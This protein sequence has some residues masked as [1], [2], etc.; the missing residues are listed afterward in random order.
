MFAKYVKSIMNAKMLE[1]CSTTL[2]QSVI[3]AV[4][5]DPRYES[6]LEERRKFYKKEREWRLKY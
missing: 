2:P 1:V 5:S 3:P 4:M 6:H